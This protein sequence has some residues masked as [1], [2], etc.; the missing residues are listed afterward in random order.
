[1]HSCVV[2]G[3]YRND[4]IHHQRKKRSEQLL[5]IFADVMIF[6]PRPS[7]NGRREN[8]ARSV[9]DPVHFE[10]GKVVRE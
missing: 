3:P 6:L 7:Y 5:K 2:I 8:G 10:D 4:T 9:I 1:M